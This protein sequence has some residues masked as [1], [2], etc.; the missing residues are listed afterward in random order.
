[1]KKLSTK[2]MPLILIIAFVITLFP[3]SAEEL[4]SL[5][6]SGDVIIFHTNDS[7]GYIRADDNAK[8]IGLDTVAAIAAIYDGK[9][10]LLDA[11]DWSNGQP[12]AAKTKG[13]SVAAVMNLA[14]YDASAIGNHEFD[15][16][17]NIGD[18]MEITDF[19]MLA[20]NIRVTDD[21]SLLSEGAYEIFEVN[22]AQIG[23]FALTTPETFYKVNPGNVS[24][25][26]F[27]TFDSMIEDAENAL[28][29]LEAEEVDIIIALVHLGI[30]G[31]DTST[32]LA[33]ILGDRIDVIIDGHSHS[34]PSY[35]ANIGNTWVVSTG[36]ENNFGNGTYLG[37]VSFTKDGDDYV[38]SEPGYIDFDT[39]RA[40]FE[41]LAEVTELIE[42]LNLPV[43][44]MSNNV[45]SSSEISLDGERGN[46]RT[47]EAQ[48]GNIVSDAVREFTDADI[49]MFN[50]G[51][52]R[53]SLPEGDITENDVY[54]VLPYGNVVY[55]ANLKGSLIR[56]MLEHG[57]SKVEEA[58]GRFAQV[59]GVRFVYDA[60]RDP[61]NRIISV[62]VNS[63]PLDDEAVYSLAT[64]DYL[65][66]GGDGYSMLVE[67][68]K[69]SLAY[70]APDDSNGSAIM[71]DVLTW[72]LNTREY[73]TEVDGRI[74]NTQNIE[75]TRGEL[76]VMIHD[77]I[78]ENT[79]QIMLWSP[80]SDTP[81]DSEYIGIFNSLRNLKIF[82]GDG[83]NNVRPDDFITGEEFAIIINRLYE[84][85]G[86]V[87]NDILM[88]AA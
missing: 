76:A 11:G 53:A 70:E 36:G 35:N 49:A 87:S 64:N 41:P 4:S 68:F 18:L 65:S 34:D 59:S 39:A 66:Q 88:L 3:L 55:K 14:G 54:T 10:L 28:D 1:M 83:D 82:L 47:R 22:G 74:I 38:I 61:M 12:F 60:S 86:A 67:A 42:E 32:R 33:E 29:A 80:F 7:H 13:T 75:I 9:Q 77:S 30:E 69:N 52:I 27:G 24:G 71:T 19:P 15:F 25:Y 62:Y 40:S 85:F 73:R 46:V 58:D 23:I 51:G 48:L 37:Y 78:P 44:E 84:Y 63:E 43:A 6:I 16:A 81:E 57:V 31:D 21:N 56:E 79:A 72:Y 8:V 26:D 20:A 17:G 45:V 2:F 5:D 50:G